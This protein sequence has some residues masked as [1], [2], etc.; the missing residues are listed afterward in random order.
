MFLYHIQNKA[1]LQYIFFK[2]SLS[3]TGSP[4]EGLKSSLLEGGSSSSA[5]SSPKGNNDREG[6]DSIEEA[7][8]DAIHLKKC[9]PS[10]SIGQFIPTPATLHPS[11]KQNQR[12]N[13]KELLIPSSPPASSSPDSS[14]VLMDNSHHHHHHQQQQ[15][16]FLC[17]QR[18]RLA[19]QT[20]SILQQQQ[21]NNSNNAASA[22]GGFT[23]GMKDIFSLMP[24]LCHCLPQQADLSNGNN[25]HPGGSYPGGGGLSPA[26][27][28]FLHHP[29]N[30]G[31]ESSPRSNSINYF[32]NSILPGGSGGTPSVLDM[33][34]EDT[35]NKV[36]KKNPS[37]PGTSLDSSRN[38]KTF[39]SG[40][41]SV[42][43][44]EVETTQ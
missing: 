27:Q 23:G 40:D 5:D 15:Q 3:I 9:H 14:S 11:K 13:N 44:G 18:L 41:D 2:C 7:D 36:G 16:Q 34:Q 29:P 35:M 28:H 24:S 12:N 22:G 39:S 30:P 19:A 25:S 10:P 6:E 20:F 43:E 26:F 42:S 37:S 21:Q 4:G 17:A 1:F 33:T 38:N 8:R 32:T 31:G